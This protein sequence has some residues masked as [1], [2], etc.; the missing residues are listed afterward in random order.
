MKK[1]DIVIMIQEGFGKLSDNLLTVGQRLEKIESL[2]KGKNSPYTESG[3]YDGNP[4][5]NSCPNEKL[6][7]AQAAET[8]RISVR[9]LDRYR[10][11][12]IIPY[13]QYNDAGKVTF[14][15]KDLVAV[16]DKIKGDNRAMD[17]FTESTGTSNFSNK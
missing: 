14:R 10:K 8:L 5:E 7:K 9:T 2:I 6:N 13:S 17:H 16:R 3:N 1:L 12:G 4:S 15:Y 11:K